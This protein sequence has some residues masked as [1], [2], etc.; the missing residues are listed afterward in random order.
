MPSKKPRGQF[1]YIGSDRPFHQI[2]GSG[3]TI[4]LPDD[5]HPYWIFHQRQYERA[6]KPKP[7]YVLFQF[8]GSLSISL[9]PYVELRRYDQVFAIDTNSRRQ[10][11]VTS[12]MEAFR[13]PRSGGFGIRNLFTEPFSPS[14]SSPEREAWKAFI[15]THDSGPHLKHCLVVDSDLGALTR[16]NAKEEPLFQEAMLPSN[17]QL[18]YATSDVS[19]DFPTVRMM[20]ACEKL[21]AQYARK[22]PA[23]PGQ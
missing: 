2:R 18:N 5:G 22:H 1:V 4:T 19:D 8:F 17:W 20:I 21:N 10:Q 14:S 3:T 6:S 13:H 16:I 23:I 12:A 7:I 15:D 9:D 11:A